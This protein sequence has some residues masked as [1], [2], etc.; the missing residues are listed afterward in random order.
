MYIYTKKCFLKTDNDTK[1]KMTSQEFS[2]WIEKTGNFIN[3]FD[4]F[5]AKG[6][7]CSSAFFGG[8]NCKFIRFGLKL[9][10]FN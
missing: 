5:I 9:S 3:I 1:I 10:I 6:P 4:I 7:H 2:D 8:G